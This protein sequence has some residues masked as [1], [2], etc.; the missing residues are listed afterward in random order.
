LSPVNYGKKSVVGKV[1]SQ[2]VETRWLPKSRILERKV[3][4]SG[5]I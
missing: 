2:M 3:K 1:G 4:H 5:T